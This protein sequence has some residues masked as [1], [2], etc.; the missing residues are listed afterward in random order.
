MRFLVGIILILFWTE[1]FAQNWAKVSNDKFAYQIERVLYDSVHNKL[2]ASSKFINHVGNLNV[3]GVATWDGVNWDSLAGGVNTHDKLLNPNNPGGNIL[4]GISYNGKFLVGGYFTSIGGINAT[5]LAIWD[6]TK[7]DSLPK[8]AFRYGKDAVVL[9]FQK[10]GNLLYIY[11]QFDSIAGQPTSGIAIWD[12]L[13]FNPVLL[14]VLP[15]FQ[16]VW[17]MIEYENELYVTGGV[18]NIDSQNSRDILKFNG[19]AWVSTTDGGLQG[20]FSSVSDLIIFNNELYACGHFLQV[21]GN[22]AN[23]IMKWNGYQWQDIGFGNTQSFI[24]INKMLVYHNKLWVF[25][26]FTKVANV[27]TSNVAVYDGTVWC[28]LKDT[29]DNT[30]NSATVYNDT[31]YIGGG[32]WKVNSDSI[33]FIAKLSDNDLYSQCVN[34]VGINETEN[35]TQSQLL[36]YPNPST[37]KLTI[38]LESKNFNNNVWVSIYSSNGQE[39]YNSEF[40]S[41]AQ[42]IEVNTSNFAEGIYF[43][44]VSDKAKSY[45]AKF[46]KQ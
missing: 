40:K 27:F 7:W 10:K 17:S 2:I 31:I 35:K 11:G 13:N 21:N 46:I 16:G 32:F 1:T 20:G 23:N 14:P 22:P 43:I 19:T 28:G 30:I 9:G 44:K 45:T 8:R 26:S 12:G 33:P 34:V 3:R 39:V 6:G 42:N 24:L 15:D 36:V 4:A 18:F 38:N 25:G 5:G 37:S 41:N 29:I